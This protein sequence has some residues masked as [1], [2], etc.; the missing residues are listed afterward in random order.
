VNSGGAKGDGVSMTLTLIAAVAENGVI[1]RGGELPWRL[2]ADLRRFR[3]LTMGRAVIM[4]R[5]TWESIG[6]PL[7]GRRMIVVTRRPGYRAEGAA[8][9]G[10]LAEAQRLAGEG[11]RGAEGA[12]FVIGGGEVYRQALALADRLELTRVHAAVEG[13]AF[14]PEIDFGCWRL[15]ASTRHEADAK[16]EFPFTFE[17]YERAS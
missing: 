17:S 14:F 3:E 10:S 5:R 11:A 16:N 12:A 2:S 7:P 15:V 8:T 1:G 9:A 13:D 6:R 4:G